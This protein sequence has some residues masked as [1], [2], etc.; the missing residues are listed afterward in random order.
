MLSA[1]AAV[2]VILLFVINSDHTLIEAVDESPRIP[3]EEIVLV[4]ATFRI[5]LDGWTIQ[6]AGGRSTKEPTH[7]AQGLGHID[8]SIHLSISDPSTRG[9]WGSSRGGACGETIQ[10]ESGLKRVIYIIYT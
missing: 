10:R 2:C 6:S 8:L 4:Q 7:V 3:G 1:S 9:C 5:G